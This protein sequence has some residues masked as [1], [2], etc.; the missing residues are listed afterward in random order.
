MK[1]KICLLLVLAGLSAMIMTGCGNSAANEE[2]KDISEPETKVEVQQTKK[3]D[4]RQELKDFLA[5]YE[6]FMDEYVEFMK[7]YKENDLSMLTHYTQILQKY[8]DFV[9]KAKSWEGNDLNNE[10]LLYY[11]DVLNRV[12]Q[13]LLK[14]TLEKQ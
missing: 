4:I 7:N 13:K 3:E 9:Q 2:K 1:K 14:V 6:D 5:S 10:E 8:T 11:T 12:S